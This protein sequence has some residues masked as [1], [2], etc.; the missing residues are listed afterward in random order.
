MSYTQHR[1]VSDDRICIFVSIY[2]LDSDTNRT[3][4]KLK[5]GFSLSWGQSQAMQRLPRTLAK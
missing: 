5:V 3:T 2:I 1:I 4:E